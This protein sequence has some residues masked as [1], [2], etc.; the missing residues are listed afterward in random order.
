M[1]PHL[2]AIVC[3]L[4][5][6]ITVLPV[7]WHKWRHPALSYS[8]NT[9]HINSIISYHITAQQMTASAMFYTLL[10]FKFS[11]LRRVYCCCCCHHLVGKGCS[12]TQRWQ[13]LTACLQRS[14]GGRLLSIRIWSTHLLRGQPGWRWHWLL[15]GRPRDRLPWQLSAL[16]AGTLSGSL[17]MWPKRALRSQL[18]V[19]EIS[20]LRI[21]WCHLIC[22]SCLW[23]FMWKAS[24]ALE[25]IERKVSVSAAAYNKIDCNRVW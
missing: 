8:Q 21:N 5:Y 9:F 24:R 6:G 4:P 15:S 17:A 19:S 25:S 12:I 3:H 10:S 20:S 18:M 22:N 1:E 11:K 7:T 2:T 16:W 13:R 14:A 23:H